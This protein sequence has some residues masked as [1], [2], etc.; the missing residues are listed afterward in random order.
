[1]WPWQQI[2]TNKRGLEYTKMCGRACLPKQVSACASKRKQPPEG[3]EEISKDSQTAFNTG[4]I[5]WLM[6]KHSRNDEAM[7]MI[8]ENKKDSLGTDGN[9]RKSRRLILR[10][11]QQLLLC[12]KALL[13]TVSDQLGARQSL[14][15][16]FYLQLILKQKWRPTV[17]CSLNK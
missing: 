12:F 11:T 15:I 16:I 13:R 8:E 1:M 3:K 17:Y 5:F 6:E 10:A 2:D 4:K 14:L 9:F 7:H